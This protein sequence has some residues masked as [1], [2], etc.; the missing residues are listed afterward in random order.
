MPCRDLVS[1]RAVAMLRADQ[2]GY[3]DRDHDEERH[4]IYVVQTLAG[5]SIERRDHAQQ[6]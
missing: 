3:D 5:A 1:Q 6:K 4:D 2:Q